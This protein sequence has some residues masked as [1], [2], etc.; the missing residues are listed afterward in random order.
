M[1]WALKHSLFFQ[2]NDGKSTQSR[3][4]VLNKSLKQKSAVSCCCA[5]LFQCPSLL[6]FVQLPLVLHDILFQAFYWSY[7]SET[8]SKVFS[9]TEVDFF[10]MCNRLLLNCLMNYNQYLKRKGLGLGS[11]C[12]TEK[13]GICP[14][15]TRGQWWLNPFP[16]WEGVLAACTGG[17]DQKKCCGLY[18]DFICLCWTVL[19][20]SNFSTKYSVVWVCDFAQAVS[21]H[22]LR[23]SVYR[24]NT[25]TNNVVL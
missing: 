18:D 17:V 2:Y 24:C 21:Q 20:H 8:V 7:R 16:A 22:S 9:I 14:F 10:S 12:N 19:F 11:P 15:E 4:N 25:E 1:Y 6:D 13:Q 23:G 5:W 3:F